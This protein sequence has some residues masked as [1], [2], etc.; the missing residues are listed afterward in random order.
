M[1]FYFSEAHASHCPGQ[2]LQRGV[3][4]PHE[5]R[6]ARADALRNAA[7]AAGL[8]E[9]SAGEYGRDAIAAVHTPAYLEFLESGPGE[10]A[11]APGAGPEIV[12]N[13]HP[14]G[15]PGSYP[16]SIVGRAGWHL[17][18]CSAPVG[19]GT[20]AAAI[21]AAGV[22]LSAAEAIAGGAAEAYALC[23]PPGHHAFPDQG[24]GHCYLN[25]IAV[26]AT[27]LR[28]RLGRLAILDIDV[29][30]GNGTQAVFYRSPDV[31]TVSV[32]ADPNALYPFFWGH[33]HER[34]EGDGTGFNLNL[35][36]A[37]GTGDD[38]WLAAIGAGLDAISRFAPAALLVALGLDAAADD[39]LG[40]LKV[41]AGGFARAGGPIGRFAA[42]VLLVQEGGYLSPALGANLEAFLDGFGGAR[43]G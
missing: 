19:P 22:A 27:W 25:N 20:F 35:P 39:P 6:P 13:V 4:K 10:W 36:L 43:R 33:A 26:A 38:G 29:H 31:F 30:H 8:T 7:L 14:A 32:H 18:D 42:P 16:A 37:P 28:P 5:D 15:A 9:R 24:G 1:D 3:M 21:A 11:T 34:G 2:F 12:P 23:R 41:T 40:A 17:S